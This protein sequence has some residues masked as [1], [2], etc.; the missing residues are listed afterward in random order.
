MQACRAQSNGGEPTRDA[1]DRARVARRAGAGPMTETPRVPN[2]PDAEPHDRRCV[3]L[4]ADID[5]HT[6]AAVR[7]RLEPGEWD[8]KSVRGAA[9]VIQQVH[10]SQKRGVIILGRP[11]SDR[12]ERAR[13]AQRLAAF[14]RGSS[15]LI[16]L[17]DEHDP[18]AIADAFST[19]ASDVLTPPVQDSRLEVR[20]QHVDRYLELEK[21]R[22]KIGENGAMMAEMSSA[23]LI[24]SRNYLY[25]ELHREIERSRRYDHDLAFL[26]MHA[27]LHS[28]ST[29]GAFRA[30]GRS[31][32]SYIRS[33]ID[34]VAR[35]DRNELAIVLPET[36]LRH[37]DF[38]AR[39]LARQLD[40]LDLTAKG[41]PA[42]TPWHFG[43]TAFDGTPGRTT[44][45][46]ASLV[47]AASGY[48]AESRRSARSKVVCGPVGD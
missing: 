9:A 23:T 6:R 48:L 31:V 34:W 16:Y 4:L 38:T 42:G 8:V 32:T 28:S 33:D 17:L 45:G 40:S 39:R 14:P 22:E 21:W 46:A 26:L 47:A 2:T 41:V 37:A 15:Y 29:E 20:L 19:G 36:G 5:E 30:V 35:F 25:N 27:G 24:H 7:R 10:A 43:V 13:L 18:E 3:V 44:P 1:Q 12:R 11:S